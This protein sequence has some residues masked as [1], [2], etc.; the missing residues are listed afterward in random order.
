MLKSM[1]YGFDFPDGTIIEAAT[2]VI[3]ENM[4]TQVD[5]YG[6]TPTLA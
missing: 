6:Y 1:V 2:N 5:E 3:A 4:L